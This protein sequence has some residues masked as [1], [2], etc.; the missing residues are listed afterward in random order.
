MIA[1]F[2]SLPS[3]NMTETAGLTYVVTDPRPI[4]VEAPYTFFLPSAADLATIVTGD[5]VQLIFAYSGPF[6]RWG[7]ERMWVAIDRIDDD[8]LLGTLQNEPDEPRSPL[9]RGDQVRFARAS[10]IDIDWEQAGRAPLPPFKRQYWERCLVDGCV[11][12]GGEPVEYLYREEPELAAEG[13]RDPDSGWRIRGRFGDATDEE[14]AERSA[15]YVAVG[16]VLN[17]DDSWL[18]LIDAPAGLAFVPD[19]ATNTY[20]PA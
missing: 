13:D 16:A 4:A 14:L 8:E 11:L 20:S 7:A 9:R 19:F 1:K 10:I 5:G 18:S 6:E 3:S 12:D 17:R 2:A 15:E